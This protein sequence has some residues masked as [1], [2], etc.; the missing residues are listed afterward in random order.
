M[1]VCV[2]YPSSQFRFTPIL[3]RF[4]YFLFFYSTGF[5]L[6]LHLA[7]KLFIS[8]SLLLPPSLSLSLYIYIYICIYINKYVYNKVKLVTVVEGDPKTLFSIVTTPRCRWGATPFPGL[9]HFTLDIYLI[10]LNVKEG[11]IKCH[12]LN[13]FNMTRPGD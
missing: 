7:V 9:F 3:M 1:C 11:G 6:C 12:F 5:L 2:C 13:V 8:L 10:I 4:F